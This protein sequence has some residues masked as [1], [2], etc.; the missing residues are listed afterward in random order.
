M[1]IIGTYRK[2]KIKSKIKQIKLDFTK[3]I[4]LDLNVENL[5]FISAIHKT[6]KFK[7]NET[8]NYK[9]NII[10]AKNVIKLAKKNKIKNIIFFSTIDLNLTQWPISKKKYILSKQK[11]ENMLINEYKKG[12]LKKLILLRLPA[13]IGKNCNDNFLKKLIE[14]LK[15]N[16]KI[17]LWDQSKIYNNFIH[18]DKLCELIYFL[19]NSKN[20][21]KKFLECKCSGNSKLFYMV[22]YAIKK[23]N[24]KSKVVIKNKRKI[25]NLKY[26]KKVKG[27]D[28]GNNFLI[29]KKYLNQVLN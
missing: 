7:L 26:Y 15:K 22:S 12:N 14:N 6:Q 21:K 23:I 8:S 1:N 11:I 19:L 16:K 20:I 18:I 13:I 9:K 10:I 4:N 27:F 24:S 3:K 29:F 5:I 28:F 25:K 2:N 17:T